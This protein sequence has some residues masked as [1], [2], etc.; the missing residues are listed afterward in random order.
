MTL[1]LVATP[2]QDGAPVAYTEYSVA[3]G[4]WKHGTKVTV[5]RQD[6][7]TVRYRSADTMGNVEATKSCKVRIDSVAP[8]VLDYGHPVAWQGGLLRC[9]YKVMDASSSRVTAKLAITRYHYPIKQYGLGA[10]PVGRRLVTGVNC[11]LGVGTWCWRV[12]A[13][14]QAGNRGLGKWHFVEV[15]PN[16]HR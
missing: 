10:Q 11:E 16:Y 4:K 5:K 12:V 8:V 9:A 6:V 3:G 1:R 13:R 14:D 15:Y 2:A 7:T